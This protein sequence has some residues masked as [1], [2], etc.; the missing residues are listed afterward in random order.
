[1]WNPG[2]KPWFYR[3]IWPILFR[4][5]EYT[6]LTNVLQQSNYL[7][8]QTARGN[9]DPEK[10]SIPPRVNRLAFDKAQK[11]AVAENQSGEL[12]LDALEPTLILLD[13]QSVN[14]RHPVR[15]NM[16]A[17]LGGEDKIRKELADALKA[18]ADE[19]NAEPTLDDPD[20]YVVRWQ[21]T[22][23]KAMRVR[24]R[25]STRPHRT[26]CMA[27]STAFSTH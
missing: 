26:S 9:F 16:L 11:R 1:M 5:D 7:H 4:A 2:Y 22:Y 12:F 25:R 20:A 14:R 21:K 15:K 6:Y 24:P 8:N 13:E 18:F 27:W 10:L 3:D 19:V 23:E 17:A